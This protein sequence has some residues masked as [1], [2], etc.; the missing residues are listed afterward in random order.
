MTF[1]LNGFGRS[2][3]KSQG[4][5]SKEPVEAR[6]SIDVFEKHFLEIARHFFLAF[7]RPQ[8]QAWVDAFWKAEQAFPMPFGATIAHAILISINE[9][10]SLR[11]RPFA[12]QNPY[13]THCSTDITN[14]ERYLLLALRSVRLGNKSQASTN[15]LLLCENEDTS[16]FLESLERLSIITGDIDDPTYS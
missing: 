8:S 15:A 10:R 5:E 16:A 9:L 6:M 3:Q 1:S 7:S 2:P 14:E 12:F 11:T 4:C 13:C